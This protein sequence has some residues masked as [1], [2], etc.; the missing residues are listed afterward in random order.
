MCDNLTRVRKLATAGF[1]EQ[2]TS[3]WKTTN[4]DKS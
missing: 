4:R 2:T 1:V 3:K